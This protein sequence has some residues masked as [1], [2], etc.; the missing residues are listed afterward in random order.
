[1]TKNKGK[2]PSLITGSSGRPKESIAE[3]TRVCTR[4][5]N[6][7]SSGEKCFEIPKV[8]GA[9]V[10]HKTFC[11]GCFRDVLVETRKDLEYFENLLS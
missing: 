2:T 5:S 3:R 4:C 10:N 11:V 9:Y 6:N 1:M 8:G 7:I